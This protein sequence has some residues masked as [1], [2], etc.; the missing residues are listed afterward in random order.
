MNNIETIDAQRLHQQR[1]SMYEE[2][3]RYRK[4]FINASTNLIDNKYVENSVCP[5]CGSDNHEILIIKNGGIY[6]VC[7]ECKMIFLNPVFKDNELVKYYESNNSNQAIAHA[8]ETDF[9]R[10]IYSAGLNLIG[11]V[12]GYGNVLDIGCSSG[13]FLDIAR[14]YKYNTY[15]IE[16]NK[17][18]VEI[19]QS[20]GHIVWDKPLNKI[21]TGFTFDIITLW[22]VF[23]HIKDGVSYLKNLH[24]QLAKGGIVFLQIPSAD[25]LAAR[26]MRE[27]CNMFDGLE[28]V[29]L[30]S[31]STITKVAIAAGYKIKSV[32]SVI[33]ELKPI[34]NYLNYEDPYKGSFQSQNQFDFLTADLIKD[35][36]FGYKLQVV[37]SVA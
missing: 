23:E 5:V 17:A 16:I 28:H 2:A 19:A 4:Y 29:N 24:S 11:E 10:R 35:R 15:G 31:L 32:F 34:L 20:K 30:Y 12:K 7:N 36:H 33:D 3:D 26:I 21:T 9:Y 37:L 13:L 6:V 14:E 22:D 8:S 18:E 1:Q 27:K 25:S